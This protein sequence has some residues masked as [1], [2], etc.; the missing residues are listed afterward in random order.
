MQ[1]DEAVCFYLAEAVKVDAEAIFSSRGR[2]E[3]FK[4]MSELIQPMSMRWGRIR[5]SL[6]RARKT[7]SRMARFAPWEVDRG[8]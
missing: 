1:G 3:L 4:V 5:L 6:D 2:G 8:A 7:G